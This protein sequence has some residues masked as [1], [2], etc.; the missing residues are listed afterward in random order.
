MNDDDKQRGNNLKNK[1]IKTGGAITGLIASGAVLAI[2]L[3]LAFL[4]LTLPLGLTFI[5]EGTVGVKTTFGE[6]TG[7]QLEPGLHYRLPIVQQIHVME[8]RTQTVTTSDVAEEEVGDGMMS[9]KSSDGL[10]IGMDVSVR[11][12]L[13]DSNAT[14]IYGTLG[15]QDQFYDR[16]VEPTIQQSIRDAASRY[17]AEQ[18]YS[19]T[20]GDFQDDVSA[21]MAE[22]GFNEHGLVVEQVQLRDVQLPDS[23]EEAIEEQESTER[24]IQVRQNQIEVEEAEAERKRVEAEGVRDA[25]NIIAEADFDDRYLQY[26]WITEG[27]E[28]GD[29]IYMPFSEEKGLDMFKDIDN[30]ESPY[31]E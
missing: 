10:N 21:E 28:K 1:V 15:S 12:R 26:L 29:V 31:Q 4:I 3:V 13:P 25:E 17:R 20:R 9:V 30:I 7:E 23:V 14:R 19:E 11:Y 6:V 8:T 16:L 2:L 5:D 18:V 22:Q 27:L 24:Q